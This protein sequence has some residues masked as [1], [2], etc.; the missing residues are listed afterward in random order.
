MSQMT[1][2]RISIL[3]DGISTFAG[4]TPMVGS[5]YS[6]RYV[7]YSGFGTMEGTWWMQTIEQLG[8]SFLRNNSFTGAYV[9]Y[10]GHYPSLLPGR[11]RD[12]A[13]ADASPDIIL[14]YTGIN[15]AVN[16][17]PLET[18]RRDYTEMLQRVRTIHPNA[19]VWAGTLCLGQAPAIAGRPYYIEP[20]RFQSL[21][22]YN[23][24]IRDC[25]ESSDCHLADLAAAGV[26]YETV[27]GIHPDKTGMTT[28]ANGWAKL[29]QSHI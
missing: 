9:S 5:F 29:L 14:I 23:Q 27:D 15:D 2:P 24:V 12:L 6:S 18:F 11:I 28:F 3:G 19:Q 22:D 26:T 25:V 10:V 4:C 8:G 7:S 21:K 20:E 13:T 17:V 16:E 1:N